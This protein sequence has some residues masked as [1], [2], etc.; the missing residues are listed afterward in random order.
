MRPDPPRHLEGTNRWFHER[1]V[2]VRLHDV[3]DGP[4][5][6]SAHNSLVTAFDQLLL[7]PSIVGI[8]DRLRLAMTEATGWA[9]FVAELAGYLQLVS[10]DFHGA[11][12]AEP[13]DESGAWDLALVC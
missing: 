2:A 4:V 12:H 10:D 1:T 9:A 3:P 7:P 11:R 6:D 13:A 5:P 8:S